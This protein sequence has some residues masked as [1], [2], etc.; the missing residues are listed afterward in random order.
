MTVRRWFSLNAGASNWL[1]L[2]VAVHREHDAVGDLEAGLLARVLH[3]ANEL[4]RQPLA[5][6][7]VVEL[8][9]EAD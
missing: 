4:A 3:G 1:W 6:Q 8:R 5:A 9:I 2:G 7:R